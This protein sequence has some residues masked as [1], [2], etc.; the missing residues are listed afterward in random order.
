MWDL[1]AT[2]LQ[3]YGCYPHFNQA[4][5]LWGP[6]ALWELGLADNFITDKGLEELL[7]PGDVVVR[8]WNIPSGNLT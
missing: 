8:P 2:I 3:D 7:R 5:P 6:E 4:L 1:K